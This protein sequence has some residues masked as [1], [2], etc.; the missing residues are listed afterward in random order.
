MQYDD[1]TS[2]VPQIYSSKGSMDPYFSR[3]GLFGTVDPQTM[4]FS[5]TPSKIK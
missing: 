1:S 5:E 4:G 3:V 2:K